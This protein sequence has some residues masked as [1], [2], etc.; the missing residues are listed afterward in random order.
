GGNTMRAGSTYNAADPERQHKITMTAS[1]DE[2]YASVAREPKNE[3][4]KSLQ[5]QVSKQLEAYVASGETYVFDSPEWHALN[6]YDGGD[7]VG[8]LSLIY[9]MTQ[10]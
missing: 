7:Q 9:N 4:H 8:D 5:E 1:L 6:T 3:L 2:V 10:N